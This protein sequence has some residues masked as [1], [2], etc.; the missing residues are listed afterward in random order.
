VDILAATYTT[1][2]RGC[3]KQVNA[4][5]KVLTK[6]TLSITDFLQLVKAIA[7]ELV[8]L[9]APVDNEDLTD[10]IL[11]ELGDDYRELVRAVQARENA[12]SFDELHEKLLMFEA[13]LQETNKLVNCFPPTTHPTNRTSGRYPFTN[14]GHSTPK[15]SEGN[16]HSFVDQQ[17]RYPGQNQ[18]VAS[19]NTTNSNRPPP[20]LYL[21]YSQICGLQGHTAKKCPSFR[22][23]PLN[24]DQSYSPTLW[25]PQA[26]L[27][28]T[29]PPNR[30]PWLLDSGASYH[31]T[32]DLQNL[33]HHLP[34]VD[35]D[36]VM[37]RDIKGLRIRHLGSTKLHSSTHS[38]NLHNILCVP[39]I[40]CNLLYVYQFCVDNNVSIEFLPWCFLV[41][42]LL[43]GEIHAKGKIKEGVYDWSCIVT[44]HS[45]SSLKPTLI[46]WHFRLGH[47][48]FF[49]LK[50]I[51][52]KCNL[53]SS[54]MS[55]DFVCNACHCNKSHKLPFSV[56][57]L[58]S[59]KPLELIFSDVWTSP[60][61]FVNGFKYYVIFVDHF[62]K[63][64]WFYLL[65]KKFDVKPTFICFKAILENYFKGKIMT[66]YS[67]NGGEY[68]V[69]T[70]FFVTHGISNL[71][72]T[73]TPEHNGFVER[74]H[75]YIVEAGL[76]LLTYASLPFFFV[77]C[78]CYR[79]LS[80]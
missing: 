26:N 61:S 49:V 37:I 11:K 70:E 40:K 3:I 1:P 60:L 45:F 74:R 19:H 43:T 53:D 28:V 59:H 72:T 66:L 46:N 77:L 62:T 68:I 67:D 39:D 55:K 41:K 65:K 38:F 33:A 56:S 44:P 29:N 54:S 20:R 75:R 69:L 27:A 12:I 63:Y 35:T 42:D 22:L 64:I 57:I 32:S 15:N 10:K 21:S 76:S 14:V 17:H 25:Q 18:F 50:T 36:D 48:S 5:L 34:Y 58:I 78:F 8:V 2:S 4:N 16:W 51:L 7:D 24:N 13:S 73:H 31:I 30:S 6:G 71:R 47:P 9:G 79:G 23:V 52:T 80:H